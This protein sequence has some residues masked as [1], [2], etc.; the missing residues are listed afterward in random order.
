[1]KRLTILFVILV[2]LSISITAQQSSG[3]ENIKEA[4][5]DYNN[6]SSLIFNYGSIGAPNRLSNIA[7]FAWHGLGY[8]FEFGPLA[9]AKVV[10]ENEERVKLVS[11]SFIRSSPYQGDYSP[12]LT[13]KWGWLPRGGYANP[14][15]NVIAIS[16]D[17]STWPSDWSEWPG[18]FG[19]GVIVGNNEAY[20]V[21][22]DFGN[23]EFKYYPF[24]ADT[25]K[26]GL[27]LSSEVRIYQIGSSLSD[28]VIVKYKFVNESPKT[29]DSVYF[30]FHGDPHIGGTSDYSDDIVKLFKAASSSGNP[31]L[32]FADNTVYLF[33]Q[34]GTGMGGL[35]T[36]YFA[37][38]FLETPAD[39]G[40]TSFHSAPYT[41]SFPNVPANDELMYDWLSGGIDTLNNYG[42]PMDNIIN[43]GT[44][45]YSMAPG[46]TIKLSIA[47]FLSDD[48][49]DMKDDA[50]N[51]SLHF[52][53]LTISDTPN[54]SGGNE[55]YSIELIDFPQ[56]SKLSGVVDLQWNYTGTN[57]DASIVIEYSSNFGESWVPFDITSATDQSYS[58]NSELL[59]DGM[60]YVFRV[61]AFNEDQPNEYY[62]DNSNHRVGIDNPSVNAVPEVV[63]GFPQPSPP[64]TTSPLIFQYSFE[65]A[66]NQ[67][68][69]VK[70][71][72]SYFGTDNFET[73]FD[74]LK[75]SGN[76]V[77]SWDLQNF[78]NTD[79]G[80][81]RLTVSDGIDQ[82]V[83]YKNVIT[84][85]YEAMYFG[86]DIDH[87]LGLG[88][89]EFRV[90]VT[91]PAQLTDHEYEVTFNVVSETEKY[92][93]LKDI[94]SGNTLLNDFE[95]NSTFSTPAID[96][97][98]LRIKDVDWGIDTNRT[99]FTNQLPDSL[100]TIL[101]PSSLG[102]PKI[103]VSED[104]FIVFNSMDTNSAGNYI[105]PADTVLS[106]TNSEV[107]CP[108][109]VFNLQQ[110]E[111]TSYR[112]NESIL[113]TRNNGKWD[114]GEE[115]VIQPHGHTGA[116]TVMGVLLNF[117]D[118]PLPQ[119]GDTLYIYTVKPIAVDDVY[120]FTTN[121]NFIVQVEDEEIPDEF[122]LFQNY[123]NP[124]NPTTKI[125]FSIPTSPQTPLLS[126]E[127]GRG[128]VV[129]LK[130]YDILGREIRTL[131]NQ[132]LSPG[133]HEVEFN[134]SGLPSGVYF[135]R[136]SYAGKSVTK[137]LMLLK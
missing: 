87:V 76:H 99:G 70:F 15:A 29:L 9:A 116:T 97:F 35:P 109:K 64:L 58:F 23:K 91:D 101:V 65:D 112:I 14:N 54:S 28:A 34:D 115:I 75:Q 22:D 126:K 95:I 51:I 43:F 73:V 124:F 63:F 26:R 94:N 77:Y 45:P 74:E 93:S 31:L 20:Y 80:V 12:D 46:D 3:Q 49:E 88:T 122:E 27:G 66:D 133:F 5:L 61:V 13:E 1:M 32:K 136:I 82:T 48:F 18:E 83:I 130:I 39:L 62:Y 96:G 131:I 118:S 120:R 41:Q 113:A 6:I 106:Q 72:Y 24:P 85:I 68:C 134:A 25:T 40:L 132:S 107:V 119:D 56:N 37:I 60:N 98:K 71:E 108:F 7:D 50:I 86:D 102:A 38:K 36:G 84:N 111:R 114:V 117:E 69:N 129:R 104:W 90:E 92:F 79:N 100:Y 103:K 19:P 78:P 30:G 11:D 105:Y 57:L 4:I 53:W 47:I 59:A 89:P 67:S 127:R 16:S 33:D 17:P 121:S 2:S 52:N 135:Y 125:K 42:I 123:P 21:M 81:M 44:G 137:K 128:E 10:D 55:S 8:M 110:N